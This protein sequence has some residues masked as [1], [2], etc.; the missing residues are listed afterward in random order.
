MSKVFLI[1]NVKS[2]E[3]LVA[4]AALVTGQINSIQYENKKFI[5]KEAR[6][7]LTL[8][9][10]TNIVN[11]FL[12]ERIG[13]R[14][15]V[16]M[17]YIEEGTLEDWIKKDQGSTNWFVLLHILKQIVKA[18]IHAHNHGLV[19]RDLKLRN[20]LVSSD[21]VH[22]VP[23]IKISDFGLAKLFLSETKE[24]KIGGTG[25]Q[26]N[27]LYLSNPGYTPECASP[28]QEMW[29]GV[30]IDQRSDIFSF[31][32]IMIELITSAIF[33]KEL[34]GYYN[35]FPKPATADKVYAF[36]R[37]IENYVKEKRN[38]LPE[39]LLKVI[40]KCLQ[41]HRY[42]RYSSFQE[43]LD[44]FNIILDN[45]QASNQVNIRDFSLEYGGP[46]SKILM[47]GLRGYSL[48]KIS[49]L[50]SKPVRL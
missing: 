45:V 46:S 22:G 26:G 19:H 25:S 8:P 33:F 44:E 15:H 6:V 23:I 7:L 38:D 39:Q 3:L 13:G 42:M 32:I 48:H 50:S 40:L 4:K 5:D 47:H 41:I 35:I 14:L 11:C 36:Q 16:F 24:R 28:E 10:H 18:M 27:N 37:N 29:D 31:G 12:V 1:K 2:N 30:E 43:I 34:I 9:P 20:I 17:E 49:L 21:T